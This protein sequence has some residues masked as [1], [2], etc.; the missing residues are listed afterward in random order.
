ML[1]RAL[2]VGGLLAALALPGAASAQA[3]SVLQVPQV[4]EPRT[5]SPNF[6]SDTGGYGPTSNVY[7]HL[8]ALDWGITRGTAVYG[9]VAESWETS[10]DGLTVTFRLRPDMRWHD[11][12]P[13]T[14]EDVKFTYDTIIRKRYP[15]YVV[16]RSV[17]E[18]EAPDATTLVIRLHAPETG[19]VPMLGQ[20]S[21]WTAKIYPKHLW[22]DQDGFD[23]GP[24]VNAPVGSG[25]FRFVRWE[26]G[27]AVELEAF[28]DYPRGRPAVDRLLFRHVTDP[29][30]ARAEFDAG[31]FAYLPF[32][33]APPMAEVAALRRGQDPRVVFTPSHFTR[34]IQ[35][36]LA[37]KPLDDIRVR[38]A[39]GHAIDRNAM[40]RLAFAGQWK[41]EMHAS[42]ASQGEMMNREA[43]FPA[44]D[45]AAAERLLDEAGHPR[46]AGGW[47][48]AL[49]VTHPVLA[50]CRAMM[51]VLVQQLRQVGINARLESFDQATWFRRQQEKNFDISCYFT[52]YGPDPDAYR[53]HFG[54]EGGRNFMSYSNPELDTL[55]ARASGMP[56]G[57]ERRGLYHRI[58]AMV[59]RDLPYIA[60]FDE[61]KTTL[62]R[63]G[64]SGF[65]VEPEGFDRSLTWFGFYAVKP[66]GR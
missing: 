34:D 12:R 61:Q 55:A 42:V 39:I 1:R 66:P 51:E 65:N 4:S 60:L 44:P 14:A 15:A 33:Y 32:D 5:L 11:G 7:S 30:V 54:T 47:R 40:N 9:D 45:R 6:A 31:R 50:D 37:R 2:M 29:S 57:P 8:V 56:N 63:N 38:Q 10:A 18:I 3:P 35:L 52:R 26:K 43:S 49:A 21:T 36:N 59:T 17:K 20:V 64:W 41:P 23:T 25:P 27:G 16:L 22:Q 28:A 19:F 53:E 24:Y 48:F 13:V 46:G 62:I 58:Q